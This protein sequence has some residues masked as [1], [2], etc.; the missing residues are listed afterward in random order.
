[1]PRLLADLAAGFAR[2]SPNQVLFWDVVAVTNGI[3][4]AGWNR[5]WLTLLYRAQLVQ[6]HARLSLFRMWIICV[7]VNFDCCMWLPLRLFCQKRR[8]GDIST[9]VRRYLRGWLPQPGIGEIEN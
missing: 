6:R 4:A 9:F 1:M 2:V 7:S 5:C 8:R 3:V